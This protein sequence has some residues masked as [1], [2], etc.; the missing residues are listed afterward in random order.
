MTSP[1]TPMVRRRKHKKDKTILG[2][3]KRRL[4][5]V[6]TPIQYQS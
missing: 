1:K 3:E 6:C 4:N 5:V 2:G